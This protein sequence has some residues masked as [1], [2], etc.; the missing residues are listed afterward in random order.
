MATMGVYIMRLTESNTAEY[1]K[2]YNIPEDFHCYREEFPF[3][4]CPSFRRYWKD[5][6]GHWYHDKEIENY[7]FVYDGIKYTGWDTLGKTLADLWR[8]Q[9]FEDR[10]WYSANVA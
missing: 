3:G 8:P 9:G 7:I 2:Y 5:D 4:K 10:Q 1:K 6:R